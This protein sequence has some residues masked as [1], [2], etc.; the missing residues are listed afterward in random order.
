MVSKYI[1]SM[2]YARR[3]CNPVILPTGKIIIFGGTRENNDKTL[4]V[5]NPE[6]FDPVTEKWTV[7]PPHSIPR[8]Y[9][10]G[11]L[12][13]TDGRVW[14]AGTSYSVYSYELRTEI[15]SP[16]YMS[17]DRPT[18][19]GAPPSIAY[20]GQFDITTPDAS[21]IT[22]ISL[23][24]LSSTTHHY[25]TDQRLLWIQVL[26]R[27]SNT[28]TVSAPINR[29]LAPPGFYMLHVLDGGVPSKAAIVQLS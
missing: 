21:D 8:I 1:Q 14:V 3:Y 24:A 7:L 5:Y 29:R 27:T 16:A 23:V 17:E 22:A 25:N 18:I 4:A 11:A 2:T 15:F 10:S 12:L 9:H 6:M 28:I 19:S 20:G 26:G 13:L